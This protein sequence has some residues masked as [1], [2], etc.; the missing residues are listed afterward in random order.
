MPWCQ[1]PLCGPRGPVYMPRR[2][3]A[4]SDPQLGLHGSDYFMDVSQMLDGI[5]IWGIWG[6]GAQVDVLSSKVSLEEHL[7]VKR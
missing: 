7:I 6:F 4:K 5:G 1:I 3:R 2:V